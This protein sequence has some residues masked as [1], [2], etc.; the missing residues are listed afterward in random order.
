MPKMS[1]YIPAELK[2]R[3]DAAGGDV[4]WSDLAQRAFERQLGPA[5]GPGDIFPPADVPCTIAAL[6]PS[7]HARLIELDHGGTRHTFLW[8][9]SGLARVDGLS[10]PEDAR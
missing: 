10:I 5:G 9:E 6:V 1:I 7:G 3:M 2:R 8:T 4:N